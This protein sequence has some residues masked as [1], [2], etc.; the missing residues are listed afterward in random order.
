MKTIKWTIINQNRVTVGV[1]EAKREMVKAM[2][3]RRKP[4]TA[5]TRDVNARL[6][7]ITEK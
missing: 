6:Y 2:D 1:F 5:I 4:G 7:Q 3:A